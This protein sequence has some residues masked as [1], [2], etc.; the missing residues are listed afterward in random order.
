MGTTT[1]VPHPFALFAKG[2]ESRIPP[3][4]FPKGPLKPAVGLSGEQKQPS[5]AGE[6]TWKE[7]SNQQ[8]SAPT[9]PTAHEQQPT[10]D[11]QKVDF[12]K[13]GPRLKELERLY[14]NHP[15]YYD[16]LC[17][18]IRQIHKEEEQAWRTAGCPSLTSLPTV[19]QSH[20]KTSKGN[21]TKSGEGPP[22]YA[23]R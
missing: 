5:H 22:A 10:F 8:T 17:A 3:H 19:F 13:Y 15:D 2:W 11:I 21:R 18:A 7:A 23:I 12:K 1:R 4:T 16:R 14:S 6:E 9:E 20:R